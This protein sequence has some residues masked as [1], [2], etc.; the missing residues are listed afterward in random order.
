MDID[1]LL[2]SLDDTT[3]EEAIEYTIIANEKI[4]G[5]IAGLMPDQ[6][7][8][9]PDQLWPDGQTLLHVFSCR[10][11][12]SLDPLFQQ[13]EQ[14]VDCN[15][16]NKW[17]ETP[18]TLAC[19]YYNVGAVQV[20][21]KHGAKIDFSD[22]NGEKQL[23][24]LYKNYEPENVTRILELYMKHGTDTDSFERISKPIGYF[25]R[26]QFVQIYSHNKDY[27]RFYQ[28]VDQLKKAGFDV[29]CKNTEGENILHLACSANDYHAIP[30]FIKIGTDYKATDK[31]GQTP[32]DRITDSTLK[33]HILDFTYKCYTP[34]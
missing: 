11:Q 23:V 3:I 25:L 13:I 19:L 16:L 26:D 33:A 4:G 18:L 8:M 28:F 9:T 21:L 32:I 20:L 24:W 17:Q 6:L 30:V 2:P 34:K 14:T 1:V 10:A 7:L 22:L 15:V 12:I 31:K 5:P 27:K 29:N